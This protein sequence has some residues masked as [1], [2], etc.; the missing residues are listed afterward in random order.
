MNAV[1]ANFDG[2]IGP[3]HNYAGLSP[4]NI[5]SADN[6]LQV[7]NPREAALQGLAKMKR[8]AD[9]G[10][11]QG[12]LPPH[13]RPHL[14]TLRALGFTGS[15]RE[16]IT[17]AA[18]QAPAVLRNVYAASA[19]WTANA[20]TIAPSADSADG[21]LHIT[22]ANL[23]AMFHR[24]IEPETTGRVLKA[25]FPDEELFAHHPALAGGAQFG[26]EGAANHN[27]FC[28]DYGDPGLHLFVYGRKA[29]AK[30]PAPKKF[31]ARQTFEA[32]A[33]IARLHQLEQSR[34]HFVQQN[35]KAIDAGAFHNDVLAVANK[36]VFFYHQEAFEDPAALTR[37]L[38]AKAP[39]IDLHFIEVPKEAVSLEEAIKTYL[40][41]SQLISLPGSDKMTLILPREANENASTNAWLKSLISSNQPIGGL[42]FLELR[43]SMRNGGGPACLR[44]RVVLTGE[45]RAALGGNVIMDDRL[46]RDLTAWVEKHYRDQLVPDDLADPDFAE[47]CLAALDAL[48]GILKLGSIFDFQR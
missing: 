47:E 39:G 38:Q 28:S 46:Y 44:L 31:P 16:I 4:G 33:A 26:D 27:R 37:D 35:P 29:F 34:V 11:V 43:Q 10:L 19:M 23:A 21:R 22:P 12:V 45:E 17:A 25:I 15:D 32:S 42:E 1:E 40:F 8:L 5:A 41:N 9:L 36:N 13:S 30:G 2:L 3:T 18:N 7:S 6:A 14:P 48:S 24:S 20:A